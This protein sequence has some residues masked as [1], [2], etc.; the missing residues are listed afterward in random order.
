M[1]HSDPGLWSDGTSDDGDVVVSSRARLARNLAGFP[2]VNQAT[3]V[4]QG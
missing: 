2:F 1:K 4:Q 3:D